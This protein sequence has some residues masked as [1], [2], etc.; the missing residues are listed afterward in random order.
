[1]ARKHERFSYTHGWKTAP[2]SYKFYLNGEL[3]NLDYDT[4]SKLG[5]M[6]A[7]GNFK[8]AEKEL[9]RLLR[10]EEKRSG[11]CGKCV[12]FYV[13]NEQKYVYSESFLYNPYNRD[14][15]MLMYKE[16][17]HY[18]QACNNKIA[19]PVRTT[20]AFVTPYGVEKAEDRTEEYTVDLSR[21]FII[22][23]TQNPKNV[24]FPVL[25]KSYRKEKEGKI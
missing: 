4:R 25:L 9:K 1:M 10:K 8:E 7:C 13:L 20:S 3:I 15:A 17:K 21:G 16:W 23:V 19:S 2:E 24:M 14:E 6:C 18:I 22:T 5:Y 12:A 11:I